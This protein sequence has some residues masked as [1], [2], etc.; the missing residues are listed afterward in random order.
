MTLLAPTTIALIVQAFQAA[1]TE[2]PKVV[3]LYKRF[4]DTIQ[5]L[6]SKGLIS[7]ATQ[8]AMMKHADALQAGG[9]PPSWAV[10]PDPI[11]L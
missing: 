3:E 7:K 4:R 5:T 2:A 6:F 10:E 1:I 8:D 11:A 9:D